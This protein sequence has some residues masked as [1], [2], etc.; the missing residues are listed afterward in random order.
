MLAYANINKF[1]DGTDI[2]KTT[3]LTSDY[4]NSIISQIE[5]NFYGLDKRL[6]QIESIIV[7]QVIRA[8]QAYITNAD[9]NSIISK[10]LDSTYAKINT[11][12]TQNFTTKN[13]DIENNNVNNLIVD[14]EKVNSSTIENAIINSAKVNNLN[15]SSLK[16]SD[17]YI[18]GKNYINFY[19]NQ[20]GIRFNFSS[21]SNG[22][23]FDSKT[24]G[25]KTGG[26]ELDLKNNK[27][28]F[29]YNSDNEKD[30]MEISTNI[31]LIL[32]ANKILLNSDIEPQKDLEIGNKT[33]P[34]DKITA[35]Q[36]FGSYFSF[37]ADLAEYYE[38]D[39][40]YEPGTL[41]M[42]GEE[43]EATLFDA[44]KERPVLGVV[45]KDAAFILNKEMETTGVLIALK[46]RVFCKL[47]NKGKRGYQIIPDYNNPGYCL[48][49]EKSEGFPIIG[50]LIDPQKN[51][52]KV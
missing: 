50:Y 39:R 7:N 25:S 17:S 10:N 30:T 36:F 5:Q 8:N 15:L 9:I 38:T 45:S 6:T 27:F 35:R 33:N 49:V 26:L 13:S 43:T 34:V 48:A 52:I 28:I 2:D 3:P 51:I 44:K 41:L 31:N 47:S 16:I 32:K 24:K 14:K 40:Y 12:T 29:S 23:R 11:L 19:D 4:L 42:I 22:I 20:P 18:F 1:Y 46:G 21:G 37:N